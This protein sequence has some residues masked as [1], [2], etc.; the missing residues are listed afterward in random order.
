MI[1]GSLC[2]AGDDS[3]FVGTVIDVDVR[4]ELVYVISWLLSET[5]L[6]EKQ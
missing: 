6:I 3:Q 2:D 5:N 4:V 1:T